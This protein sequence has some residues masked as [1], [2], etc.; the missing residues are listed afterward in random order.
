LTKAPITVQAHIKR[1]DERMGK[2]KALREKALCQAQ[3][4]WELPAERPDPVDILIESSKGRLE[5][6]LIAVIISLS[7][8]VW[9]ASHPRLAVLRRAPGQPAVQ[10]CAAA[11]RKQNLAEPADRVT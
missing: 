6:L 10:R 3:A 5:A 4:E 2:G 11:S 1:L 9:R 8:L 7:A